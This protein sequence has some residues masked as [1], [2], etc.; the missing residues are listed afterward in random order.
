MRK[1]LQ[2]NP[3]CF[4]TTHWWNRFD[5]EA[6]ADFIDSSRGNVPSKFDEAGR[7]QLAL[8]LAQD[9][10]T[11][12]DSYHAA[13]CYAEFFETKSKLVGPEFVKKFLVDHPE[14]V[15]DAKVTETSGILPE[16]IKSKDDALEAMKKKVSKTKLDKRKPEKLTVEAEYQRDRN[17]LKNAAYR[18]R[19]AEKRA[20]KESKIGSLR[21]KEW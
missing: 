3:G 2:K 10:F 16:F 21:R 18:K 7:V 11:V 15:S 20:E 12:I 13:E 6:S 1:A 17:N 4:P 5:P 14:V 19:L 8:N 9:T